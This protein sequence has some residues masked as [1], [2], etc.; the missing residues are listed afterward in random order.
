MNIWLVQTGEPLPLGDEVKKM[1]TAILADKLIERG[2]SIVWWASSFD[3]FKK[4]WAFEKDA[5]NSIKNGLKIKALKGVGYRKNIS[6]SRLIDHRII[7]RK[8]QKQSRNM[9]KPDVIVASMP[10]HDLAYEVVRFAKENN[11]PVLVDI[12]D[13]WPE[14]FLEHVPKA[15]KGIAKLFLFNDFRMVQE[16]MR[17][18]TGLVAV[19]GSFL[20]WGLGYSGRRRMWID[21]VFY[22]GYKKEKNPE[23]LYDQSRF[24]ELISNIKD[25]FVVFF[26]GTLSKTYHNP[27]ILLKVSEKLA[28]YNDICFVIAGDGEL[29]KE[30]KV[31][32]EQRNNVHLTGWLNKSEID[33]FLR[34]SD[35]G[36]CPAI[37]HSDLPTNK[38]FAY[39]SAGLPI[40][41]SFQGE[42]KDIISKHDIGFNYEPDDEDGLADAIKRAYTN[43]GLYGEFSKN[44]NRIFNEN[45]NA[46]KIYDEYAQH[47]EKVLEKK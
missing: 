26:V 45:F 4:E 19:T 28:D 29:L 14:I 31:T 9:P 34:H 25:K 47:I 3:H 18:A 46:D 7:A 20:K 6:F 1:R 43:K 15:F 8:F 17:D 13:P 16:T 30:F 41:S 21:R 35:I 33:L 44:A 2:H 12:R 11:V 22:L 40:I 32:A 42:L 24:K 36:V 39:L 10:P 27:S 38:A 5:D 23:S 37:K